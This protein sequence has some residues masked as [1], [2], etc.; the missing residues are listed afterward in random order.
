MRRLLIALAVLIAPAL[1]AQPTPTTRSWNRPVDP[2]KIAG[3]VYSVGANDVTSFL[4][5]TSEGHVLINSGFVETV[6]IIEANVRRLGFRIEDV[7]LILA[8]HAHFDHVGGHAALRA[9]TGAKV[10]ISEGDTEAVRTGGRIFD[11]GGGG[12]VWPA[13]PVDRALHDG[14]TVSLGGLSFTPR[15]TPGHTK[16]AT[17]WLFDVSEG[18]RVLHVAVYSSMTVIPGVL[19]LGNPDHPGIAED[20]ARG[21]R[22]LREMR[23]DVVLAPHASFY[24]AE[25]K[26]RRLLAAEA[27]NPFVDPALWNDLVDRQ[28]RAFR[29]RLAEQKAARRGTVHA[30]VPASIEAGARYVLYLHGRILER[31]GRRAVSPDY[32]AY[33]LDA[34]LASL[35]AKGFEV[36]AEVRTG[37]VGREYA[38]R[39]AGQVGRLLEAGVP[40][41]NVTVVGASKGGWLTLETAAELGRDD[42]AF[43]VL[44][45]CGPNTV[46]LGARLRGR[47]LSVMDASDG[48][49][50]SCES[51]FAAAPRLR[52]RK[53]VVTDL[54]LGHGLLYKPLREWLDPLAEWASP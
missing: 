17:T 1:R 28:E 23:P 14:E 8:S 50:L 6:P 38:R 27:G 36:I 40:P 7:K 34:I 49:D 19:L 51:T 24:G 43:V 26:A 13:C 37:D 2:Y 42:I 4:I 32:G 30:D 48:K 15:V 46:N 18:A 22:T 47:I 52:G 41:S 3:P 12:Y 21:F 44:A 5:T 54:G 31:E 20:Y 25:E 16:G 33:A 29:E 35:A 39:V 11:S 45:G 9:K 53:Q 10:L